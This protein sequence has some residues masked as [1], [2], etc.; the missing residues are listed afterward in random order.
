MRESRSEGAYE[1]GDGVDGGP[2]LDVDRAGREKARLKRR[3]RRMV[4]GLAAMTSDSC[5]AVV[6]SEVAEAEAMQKG[7]RVEG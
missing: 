7:R 6:G 3:Q 5:G 2:M 1:R 4:V